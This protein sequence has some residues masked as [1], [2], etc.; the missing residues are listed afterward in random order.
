MNYEKLW[1]LTLKITE[2]MG[3]RNRD[4]NEKIELKKKRKK[5]TYR[6]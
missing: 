6:L 4:R 2:I 5:H 3:K 1:K